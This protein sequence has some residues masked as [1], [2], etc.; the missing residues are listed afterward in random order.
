MTPSTVASIESL[1][2]RV[3]AWEMDR[4]SAVATDRKIKGPAGLLILHLYR[5]FRW[6]EDL[7]LTPVVGVRYNGIRL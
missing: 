7:D 4:I 3:R 6:A 1:P 2:G 5:K